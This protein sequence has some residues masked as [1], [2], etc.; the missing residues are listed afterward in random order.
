MSP[1]AK[2]CM[3]QA[4]SEVGRE[5]SN[6]RSLDDLRNFLCEKGCPVTDTDTFIKRINCNLFEKLGFDSES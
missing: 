6:Q 4:C 3:K 2:E 1:M 5:I